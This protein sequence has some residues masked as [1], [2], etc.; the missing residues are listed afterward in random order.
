M[1]VLETERLALRWLEMDDAAFIL[2]LVNDPA[3]L[4]FIDDKGIHT[5]EDAR[6]YIE[7]GPVAMY[8]R[9]GFGLYLVELKE[10][11]EPMGICGLI[12]RDALEEVDVGF[13]LLPG[14]WGKGYAYESATAVMEYGRRT[15]ELSRLLAITSPDNE[16]SIRLLEKLGFHF[17]RLT[18]LAPDA[19]E[20]K[21][22]ATA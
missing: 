18:R 15:F 9:L 5:V 2:R 20:V 10:R 13:A 21:V 12:K 4:R 22:F 14:F 11:S 17:E 6:N 16:A 7:T 8:R 1:N 19:A 3:W